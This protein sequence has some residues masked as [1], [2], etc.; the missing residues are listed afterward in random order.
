MESNIILK[1]AHFA[2]QKHRDQR[3]KDNAAS[4]YINHPLRV[5]LLLSDIGK[6]QDEEILAAA[7]LHDTIEDTDTKPE[8]L[9]K[10]FGT[11]ILELVKEVTDNKSLPKDERKQIQ[12]EHAAEIST[13]AAL[14]KLGD[15]ISNV[16]DVTFTPPKHWGIKRRR[17]YFDWAEAVVNNLPKANQGL[18]DYFRKVIE[19]GREKLYFSISVRY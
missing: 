1:A 9:E 2:A 16:I 5:A 6:V 10:L 3:R 11:R 7:L 14:I 15:K 18:E 13:D 8:E 4:P 12:I 17:A 19:A